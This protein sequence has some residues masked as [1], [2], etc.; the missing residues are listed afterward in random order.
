MDAAVVARNMRRIQTSIGARINGGLYLTPWRRSLPSTP[1]FP[2]FPCG[3]SH[4]PLFL[5]RRS[6]AT[7]AATP[8]SDERLDSGVAATL[9]GFPKGP[10]LR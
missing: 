5:A 9:E 10:T 8:L 4:P 7:S 1:L 3:G 6:Q 2:P